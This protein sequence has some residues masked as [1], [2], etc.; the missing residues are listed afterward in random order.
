MCSNI[1]FI[2]EF[3]AFVVS[4]ASQ[5]S[6]ISFAFSSPCAVVILCAFIDGPHAV[7][8]AAITNANKPIIEFS[9]SE[10][11]KG[12]TDASSFPTGNLRATFEA[13][14]YTIWDCTSP[15]FLRTIDGIVVLCIP[16]AFISYGGEAL[17]NKTPLLRSMQVISAESIKLLKFQLLNIFIG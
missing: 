13:R 17:D 8:E 4:V 16:T 15:A 12:E 9:G 2:I 3:T 5:L 1:C 6:V 11:I 14:G 7:S 10:L